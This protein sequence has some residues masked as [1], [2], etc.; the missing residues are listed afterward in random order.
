[1][2]KLKQELTPVSQLSWYQEQVDAQYEEAL[3]SLKSRGEEARKSNDAIGFLKITLE[4]PP[5]DTEN[6]GLKFK[7]VSLVH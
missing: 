7:Y 5:Y 1:M 2:S 4:S 3:Q 6:E